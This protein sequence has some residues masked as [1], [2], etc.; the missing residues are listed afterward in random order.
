M[1][2]AER[3]RTALWRNIPRIARVARLTIRRDGGMIAVMK[4]TEDSA[5]GTV[6]AEIRAEL[7]RQG[8]TMAALGEQMG[9][10]ADWVQRRIA[11]T[12]TIPLSVDDLSRISHVLGVPVARLTHQPARFEYDTR[13]G[14]G[15]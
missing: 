2:R 7:A 15:S 13:E 11:V 9:R 10:S 8:M 1:T 12:R 14:T 3:V 5:S 4:T 6:A